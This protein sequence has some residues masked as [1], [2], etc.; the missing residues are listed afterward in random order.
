MAKAAG[1]KRK[2]S[3]GGLAAAKARVAKLEAAAKRKTAVSAA[4]ADVKKAQAKLAAA[5]K[6]K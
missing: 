2:S 4:Q 6:I 3:G 1:T 5:R